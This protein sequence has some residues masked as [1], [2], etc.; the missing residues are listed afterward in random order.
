MIKRPTFH[1]LMVPALLIAPGLAQSAGPGDLLNGQ[2]DG[3]S[4]QVERRAEALVER[5]VAERTRERVVNADELPEKLQGQLSE[6][7]PVRTRDGETAFYETHQIDG[8]RAVARQWFITATAEE[9]DRLRLPG[10]TILEQQKLEGLGLTVVRFQ[11]RPDIDSRAALKKLLPELSER[12]DRNHIYSPQSRASG[13][14]PNGAETTTA[15]LCPEPVRVGMVD[16]LISEE[17]SAFEQAKIVQKPF[18]TVANQTGELTA[19]RA[20]GTAVAS[21]LVGQSTAQSQPRLPGATLFNASV[22]YEGSEATSGATLAHLLEGL[23]WLAE[24]NTS[25]INISLTGPDN[26]ILATAIKNLQQKGPMLVAAVGNEGPAAPPLY[27]A[28]YEGVIGVTAVDK[29]G[30][31]YRWANRGNHV[32]F[33]ARGVDV[34]VAHP[35]GGLVLDSGTSLAAPVVTALLACSLPRMSNEQAIQALIERAEDLGAEG[36]DP[37]FGHGFLDDQSGRFKNQPAG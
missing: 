16:T 4:K 3:I 19:P 22:F 10:V 7:L 36:R 12:L 26:R 6:L 37:G 13:A 29:A 24:Q 21:V 30:A 8:S 5:K 9:L 27:P 17:H 18:L 25:V 2:I 20:H 11:V 33:A 32:A 31:L 35:K 28:A 23:N 15:S 34:L 14:V 1:W